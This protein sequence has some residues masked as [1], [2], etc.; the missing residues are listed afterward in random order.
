MGATD[1]TG[2]ARIID[3]LE[4]SGTAT[5]RVAAAMR[6]VPR[7][8]FL[9]RP[10]RHEAGIDAPIP[11]G[12]G[13]TESAPHMVAMMLSAL[14][15][16]PGQRVLEVGG[17]TGYHAACAAELVA[18]GGH[19]HSIEYHAALA[20]RARRALDGTGHG[21]SVTMHVGD[22]SE[23][24]PGYAPFDAIWLACAA[25][26][27]PPPLLDQRAP[28]ARVVA[29]VGSRGIQELVLVEMDRG[30]DRTRPLGACVFVPLLGRYGFE[31]A[32]ARPGGSDPD[33]T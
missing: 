1:D 30:R 13:Q 9:P 4:Q 22:G 8:A 10:V 24:L 17:G 32:G 15:L 11:I 16:Q 25:P 14:D 3:D 26:A 23:G 12:E 31:G 27:I 29:P 7:A 28:G 21:S 18:P 20:D 6:R 19:V 33:V 5:P 2:L